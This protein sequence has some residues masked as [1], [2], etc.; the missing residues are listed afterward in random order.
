MPSSTFPLIKPGA[1]DKARR[2]LRRKQ[3]KRESPPVGTVLVPVCTTVMWVPM[4]AGGLVELDNIGFLISISVSGLN[5]LVYGIWGV[6]SW[7]VRRDYDRHVT[8]GN[9]VY[10]D[11]R[12][13]DV[14][15]E[16]REEHE[17]TLTYQERAEEINKLIDAA[18]DLRAE[19]DAWDKAEQVDEQLA[20]DSHQAGGPNERC[21]LAQARVR[22]R[23]LREVRDLK[24]RK[25][26]EHRLAMQA[27]KDL[28]TL[29]SVHPAGVTDDEVKA[30]LAVVREQVAQSVPQPDHPVHANSKEMP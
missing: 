28:A 23:L 1:P 25:E 8:S 18:A 9:I 20:N 10:V 4:I 14:W 16:L 27:A 21:I 11:R 17:V 7:R 19:V 30:Q 15:D 6:R 2:A 3:S 24:D 12:L 29:D 13:I 22:A 5:F 26:A